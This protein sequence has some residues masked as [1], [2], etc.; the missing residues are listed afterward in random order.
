MTGLSPRFFFRLEA[1]RPGAAGQYGARPPGRHRTGPGIRRSRKLAGLAGRRLGHNHTA[2]VADRSRRRRG[3]P[4]A[5]MAPCALLSFAAS[6]VPSAIAY[7]WASVEH[8]EIGRA[9]YLR[10]CADS[11][12]HNRRPRNARPAPER[13]LRAGVRRQPRDPGQALWG[14]HRDRWR[15]PRPSVGVPVT[16]RGLAFPQQEVL[17]PAGAGEQRPLQPDLDPLLG[18]VPPASNRLRVGGGCRGGSD[19]RRTVPAGPLRERLRG[20]LSARL[21]RRRAHGVQPRGLERGRRQVVSRRLERPRARGDRSGWASLGDVR[22]R[23]PRRPR[24]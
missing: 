13:A 4:A 23:S 17:L 11:D 20:S 24:Q 8:Q 2:R 1:T 3:L 9:S 6:S 22:R 18:R 19:D 14:R 7:A 15:L 12:G 16:E 21:L 10:A 5:L